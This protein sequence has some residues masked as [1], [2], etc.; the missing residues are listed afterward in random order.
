MIPGS[1]PPSAGRRDLDRDY[2]DSTRSE[3]AKAQRVS[4]KHGLRTAVIRVAGLTGIVYVVSVVRDSLLATFYG[5]SAALDIYFLATGPAQTLGLEIASL[6]Y[7]AL[8]PEFVKSLHREGASFETQL[9]GRLVAAAGVGLA[10]AAV[11][12]FAGVAF[13]GLFAPGFTN[14]ADLATLRASL[15]VCSL[16]VPMLAVAGGLR[17]AL[18]S[19]RQFTPWAIYPGLRS[20]ALVLCVLASSAAPA[21]GWLIAGSLVGTLAG[22]MCFALLIG[23]DRVKRG[24]PAVQLA[25][26]G[27]GLPRSTFPL[28]AALGLNALTV[29]IDNSFA[30]RTGVGGVQALTLATN[31]LTV[32]QGIV[33]GV[34]ATVW[35]PEFGR[36]CAR[37]ERHAALASLGRAIRYA[38]FGLVPFVL[39]FCTDAGYAI[40]RLVYRH[41]SF[42][43]SLAKVVSQAA[44]ALALGQIPFAA[45]ILLKQFF[46][47]L[48]TPMAA[49]E[50]A[51]VYL[52]A[53][54]VGNTLLTDRLGL[55][56]VALASSVACVAVCGY[57]VLRLRRFRFVGEGSRG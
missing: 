42:D 22:P 41:G 43:A 17:A 40:T 12:T 7:L 5:G 56:G 6:I 45:L 9:P 38:A 34:V 27:V 30:S 11:L 37:R 31:L 44:S 10:G 16:L 48:D 49:L 4:L 19:R 18:E 46:I 52:A 33:G 8:L 54:W 23:L 14:R 28:A 25:D 35:F 26:L 1:G 57:L 2:D 21:L 32:P 3:A 53:K 55:P 50:A 51:A 24:D 36:L 39:L 15:A 47:A 13:T 29:V 20:A